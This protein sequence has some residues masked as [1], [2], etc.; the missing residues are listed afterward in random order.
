MYLYQRQAVVAEEK[1][2]CGYGICVHFTSSSYERQFGKDLKPACACPSVPTLP[3]G[4]HLNAERAAV[5]S[6]S[7]RGLALPA[8]PGMSLLS[9]GS[10]LFPLCTTRPAFPGDVRSISRLTDSLK[11]LWHGYHLG[12]RKS[13]LLFNERYLQLCSIIWLW[14]IWWT[15][16]AQTLWWLWDSDLFIFPS[17]F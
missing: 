3:T 8:Q 10:D 15:C 17:Y 11:S 5:C 2:F 14:Q 7:R 9:E 4:P 6:M 1:W 13:N 12:P 16:F